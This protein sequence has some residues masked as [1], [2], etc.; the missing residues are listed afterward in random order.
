MNYWS[1]NNL[2]SS[3]GNA[4]SLSF[5]ISNAVTLS[6]N[7]KTYAKVNPCLVLLD[8]TNGLTDTGLHFGTY[9]Y[10][11]IY[12]D[13]TTYGNGDSYGNDKFNTGYT[14]YIPI[15]SS[16]ATL[17]PLKGT[18][19][20]SGNGTA[21]IGSVSPLATVPEVFGHGN[22]SYGWWNSTP[23]PGDAYSAGDPVYDGSKIIVYDGGFGYESSGGGHQRNGYHLGAIFSGGN[24]WLWQ[25]MPAYGGMDGRGSYDMDAEYGGNQIISSGNDIFAGYNGEFYQGQGQ[26]GQIYHYHDSGLF[27]GQFGLVGIGGTKDIDNNAVNADNAPWASGNN[28]TPTVVSVGNTEYIYN[29]NETGRGIFRYSVTGPSTENLMVGSVFS[30]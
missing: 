13:G 17:Q 11:P 18:I 28:F 5:A 22:D 19:T 9:W 4:S 30:Q 16:T 12:P 21:S 15:N 29:G 8:P 14:G 27:I 24:D 6:S 10:M 25:T 1:P 2:P 23:V 20:I 3:C 26:A 7:G